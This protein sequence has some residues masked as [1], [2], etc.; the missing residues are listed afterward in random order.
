MWHV[1]CVADGAGSCQ[2]SRKGSEL[3]VLKSTETLRESLD[4]H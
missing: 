4:S 3:A 1:I 2:Y